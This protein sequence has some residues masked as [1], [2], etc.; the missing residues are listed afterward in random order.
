MNDKVKLSMDLRSLRRKAGVSTDSVA[1]LAGI[2]KSTVDRMETGEPPSL[3]NALRL[4]R[5]LKT[6]VEQV[7]SLTDEKGEE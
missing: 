4:A 1:A 2:G 3:L 7:W 5:F 6:P